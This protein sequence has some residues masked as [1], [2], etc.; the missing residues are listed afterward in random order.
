MIRDR[1]LQLRNTLPA[2]VELVAVSKFQPN[3][4]IMEAYR[5]GQRIFGESRPQ[6]LAAKAA[7]L[8]KDIRWHLVGHLQTNKIKLILPVVELIHSVDSLHLARAI[9]QEAEKIGR[10]VDILLQLHIARE[11]SKFGWR[12]GDLE[13][14]L[15]QKAFEPFTHL[16][17][18]G[19]MGMATYTDDTG[20]I[21]QEFADLEATY[22][23]FRERYFPSFDTLSMGMSG[24]YPLALRHGTTLVRIGTDLFGNR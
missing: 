10:T 15:Q 24:D 1:L 7:E 11:E 16:R 3:E 4:A 17:P 19:L 14:L 2:G 12:A 6:E 20:Q 5:A 8:P 9:D 23:R 22:L 21:E 13:Q 18:R